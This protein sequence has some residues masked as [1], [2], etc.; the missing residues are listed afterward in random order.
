MKGIF[1][2]HNRDILTLSSDIDL[3]VIIDKNSEEIKSIF[4][5]IENRFADIYFF[6]IDFLNQLKIRVKFLEIILTEF[7]GMVEKRKIEYDP[8]NLLSNLKD[9]IGE[10][11]P[12]QKIDD[13]EKEISGLK[14]II[15]L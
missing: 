9:K 13:S 11:S 6:D 1:Y 3:I 2:W 8:E 5:T 12:K 15:T 4:T 14:Q 7:F 10:T